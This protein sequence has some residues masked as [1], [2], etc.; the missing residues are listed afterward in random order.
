MIHKVFC[1]I[2]NEDGSNCTDEAVGEITVVTGIIMGNNP[3]HQP[4]SQLPICQKHLAE[5]DK[6]DDDVV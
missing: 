6:P 1:S 4:L 2:E 3:L 5:L